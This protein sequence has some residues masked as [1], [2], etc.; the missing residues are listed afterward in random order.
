MRARKILRHVVGG[1]QIAGVDLNV[2]GRGHARIENRVH[3]RAALEEGAHIGK[4]GRQCVLDAV[5]IDRGC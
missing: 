4:L 3:H 5:H 1:C 2:D